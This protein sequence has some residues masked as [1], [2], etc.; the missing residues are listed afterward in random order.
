LVVS[1]IEGV[2][3]QI[4]D[5]TMEV[6]NLAE[7]PEVAVKYRIMAAPAIAINGALAFSGTPKE[8]DLRRRLL[9]AAR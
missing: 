9:K 3:R 7:H 6:I 8:A 4:P 2:R 1:A 5:L